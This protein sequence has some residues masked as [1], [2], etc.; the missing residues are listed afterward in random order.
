VP[1][2]PLLATL[3]WADDPPPEASSFVL[4]LDTARAELLQKDWAGAR[5]ALAQAQA[6][7][8]AND[9]L[10]LGADLGRLDFYRGV[11]EWRV[12]DR[13]KGALDAWRR[14]AVLAPEFQPDK[15][16]L[17]D[18]EEQDAFYAIVSEVKGYEQVELA[19]PDDPGGATIF[20]DGQP[21]DVGDFLVVGTH[22]VQI[23]CDDGSLAGSWYTLGTPPPDWL[24]LCSGGTYPV[25]G[26]APKKPKDT[27][28]KADKDAVAAADKAAADKAAADKAAADKAAADKAATDK[29][30][31]VAKAAADKAAAE[32]ART[33]TST[34]PP[35]PPP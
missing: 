4:L 34:P 11:I 9:V 29:A 26:K 30:A 7:A 10:V 24:V 6:V 31:A 15:E 25:K 28:V 35:P 32:A 21:R 16:L 3:A 20:I 14:A 12:G 19:L 23:R 18:T 17:P 1:L 22:Y 8:P 33:A 2:I 5:T 13:D 27:P